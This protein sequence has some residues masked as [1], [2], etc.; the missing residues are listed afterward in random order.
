MVSPVSPTC[1]ILRRCC[2]A[3]A[4]AGLRAVCSQTVLKF[5]TPDAASYDDS[6]AAARDFIQRWKGHALITP[7]VRPHAP[8]TCTPEI[9]RAPPKLAVEFDVP[10]HTISLRPSWKWRT[11]AARMACRCPIRQEAGPV[12]CQST[13]RHC[14]HIDE[15][16]MRTLMHAGRVWQT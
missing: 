2:Q 4:E 3:T 7:S 16:E 10:L 6:L 5:P 1:T 11:C 14:V 8:Y 9:L 13:G 12:R 15:G